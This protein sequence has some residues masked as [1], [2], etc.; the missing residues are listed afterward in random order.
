MRI[1]L[2]LAFLALMAAPGLLRAAPCDVLIEST[3]DM[4][5]TRMNGKEAVREIT[6]PRS[7]AEIKVTL[8]H[9]GSLPKAIMGHNWVLTQE[10]GWLD[11]A[12]A[13]AA[14]GPANNFLASDPRI[15]AATGVIGGREQTSVVIP[16]AK[17]KDSAYRFFCSFPG[18]ATSMT[19]RFLVK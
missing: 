16:M 5:F 14:A 6:V 8:R 3:D 11:I 18:H 1:S 4:R 13:S 2:L 10:T 9:I 17:L 12:R 15:V 7:C 19:G